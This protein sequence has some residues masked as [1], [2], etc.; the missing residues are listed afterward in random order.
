MSLELDNT[1]LLFQ[2][3]MNHILMTFWDRILIVNA[4]DLQFYSVDAV[5][6]TNQV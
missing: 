6:H 1:S 4:D 3:Y 2:R 5:P